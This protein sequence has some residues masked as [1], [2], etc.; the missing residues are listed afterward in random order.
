MLPRKK[1]RKK[2]KSNIFG[3]PLFR[4]PRAPVICTGSPPPRGWRKYDFVQIVTYVPALGYETEHNPSSGQI[5]Y[6]DDW[7]VLPNVPTKAT[8]LHNPEDSNLRKGHA[9][10]SIPNSQVDSKA[11]WDGVRRRRWEVTRARVW[12]LTEAS[13]PGKHARFRSVHIMVTKQT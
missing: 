10:N 7:L 5:L 12:Y 3:S 13:R 9:R 11:V 1:E 6:S 4:T 8:P 2:E